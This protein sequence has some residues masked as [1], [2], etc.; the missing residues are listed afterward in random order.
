MEKNQVQHFQLHKSYFIDN[1]YLN[2]YF[3]IEFSF[4]VEILVSKVL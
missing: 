1:Q 4:I 2:L 3:Y